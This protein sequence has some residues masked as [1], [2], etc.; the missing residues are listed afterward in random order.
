MGSLSR[1]GLALTLKRLI[2][3]SRRV[4]RSPFEDL[5]RKIIQLSFVLFLKRL[6]LNRTM[7]DGADGADGNK[8]EE[9]REKLRKRVTDSTTSRYRGV[10]KHRRSGRWESH[11]WVSSKN[12]QIY[13]G[14]YELEE[15]AAAAY[16][17]VRLKLKGGKARTNFPMS[18]YQDV[19]EYLD[20]VPLDDLVSAVRRQSQGFARCPSGVKWVNRHASG[21]WEAKALVG[22]CS[23]FINLGLFDD[24]ASATA[25]YI[26]AMTKMSG[27]N[28][29]TI[30]SALQ[31]ASCNAEDTYTMRQLAQR[32][33]SSSKGLPPGL[34]TS[35]LLSIAPRP[36]LNQPASSTNGQNTS[37]D[38]LNYM[39]K[40]I[41]QS[42]P[43]MSSSVLK[44]EPAKE[45]VGKSSLATGTKVDASEVANGNGTKV[46]EV[47]S[48]KDKDIDAA[49][50]SKNPTLSSTLA[51]MWPLLQNS[52]ASNGQS[53]STNMEALLASLK[54]QQEMALHFSQK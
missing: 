14:G 18:M 22:S 17:T 27:A 4:R 43:V 25:A 53:N 9:E 31:S 23:K 46:S 1:T 3:Y 32:P 24:Q 13:L 15:H 21:K 34:D 42:P 7:A 48:G 44:Q 8:V 29:N 33:S 28:N 45:E 11:I 49:K 2:S 20:K 38:I 26:K 12:K 54:R 41:Q 6:G 52:T 36:A 16:D 10:T 50:P 40:L 47:A 35:T 30:S 37:A 51:S 5:H 39:S 19:R